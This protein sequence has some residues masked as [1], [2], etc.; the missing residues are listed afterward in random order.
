MQVVQHRVI[1]ARYASY[2]FAKVAR[3][4]PDVRR[5]KITVVRLPVDDSIACAS[6][7]TP[8]VEAA[9][10]S[11]SA[12]FRSAFQAYYSASAPG[13]VMPV[14]FRR[15]RRAASNMGAV[16]RKPEEP[17]SQLRGV[18]VFADQHGGTGSTGLLR[19]RK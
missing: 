8:R 13:L 16:S 18:G 2:E 6:A 1:G 19:E 4:R 15:S 9:A 11:R 3:L 10:L 14:S 17:S 12:T 7:V 5:S